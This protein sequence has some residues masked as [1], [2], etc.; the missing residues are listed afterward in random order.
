MPDDPILSIRNLQVSYGTS[1]VLFG[2]DLDVRQGEVVALLGRNGAGKST[3]FKSIMGLAPPSSG[4]VVMKGKNF[5]GRPTHEIAQ[6]GLAY[7]PEDRQVFPFQT[8]EDNLI[9]AQKTG[10]TGRN[11]WDLKAIYDAF[12]IV[13][14]LKDRPAHLLSGGE[15]QLLTIARALMGNPDAILLDEP[16]EGLAPI[17]V[18]EIGRLIRRLKNLSVTMLIAEQ[19]MHFCLSVATNVYILNK[20]QVVH[21]DT[22]DRILN[23]REIIQKY[24]S[25]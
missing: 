6:A 15:Q 3:T 21:H 22:A 5:V 25:V 7:V 4:T 13:A 10:P 20:G 8:V 23:N 24:L 11:D 12:P 16:S 2:V 9:I 19:N 14:R 18:Q 17:I 1:R